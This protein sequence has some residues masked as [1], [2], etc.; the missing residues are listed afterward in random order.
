MRVDMG[1]SY[2]VTQRLH[3]IDNSIVIENLILID[4]VKTIVKVNP[5]PTITAT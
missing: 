4:V 5:R 3:K 2:I 1:A